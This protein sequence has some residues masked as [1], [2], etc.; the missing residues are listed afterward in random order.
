MTDVTS[1][2]ILETT[3]WLVFFTASGAAGLW[4]KEAAASAIQGETPPALRIYVMS[5]LF[6]LFLPKGEL[7]YVLQ[8]LLFVLF[9][10]LFGLGV[11]KPTSVPQAIAAGAGWTAILSRRAT[12]D[13]RPVSS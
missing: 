8:L 3:G 9:G 12:A 1:W 5:D 13:D 10:T 2:Q 4:F 6:D 11:V 7:N